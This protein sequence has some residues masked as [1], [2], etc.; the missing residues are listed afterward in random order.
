MVP[1]TRKALN[2]KET[3]DPKLRAGP[4]LAPLFQIPSPDTAGHRFSPG[5]AGHRT[6]PLLSHRG[7]RGHGELDMPLQ[8]SNASVPPNSASGRRTTFGGGAGL[9][10]ATGDGEIWFAYEA[11]LKRTRY[12]SI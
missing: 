6:V 7:C 9:G 12:T 1:T 8:G 11:C 10:T 3:T 4:T 5:I 2:L